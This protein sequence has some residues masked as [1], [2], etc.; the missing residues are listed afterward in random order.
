MLV[1]G[2]LLYFYLWLYEPARIMVC[3][4]YLN[5]YDNPSQI[6]SQGKK[7]NK[8]KTGTVGEWALPT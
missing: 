5:L 6:F 4:H 1:L 3:M 7:Q 8:Q 2:F